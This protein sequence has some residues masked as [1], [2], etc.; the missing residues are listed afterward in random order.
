MKMR[1]RRNLG[2][3]LA[4]D[5][6]VHIQRALTELERGIKVAHGMVDTADD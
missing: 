3:L 4:V 2:V 5:L 1:T 6:D